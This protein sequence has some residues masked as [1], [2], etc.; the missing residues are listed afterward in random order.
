[1]RT[2]TSAELEQIGEMMS[3]YDLKAASEESTV[4]RR[5]LEGHLELLRQKLVSALRNYE[6]EEEV[7]RIRTEM[8]QIRRNL[9]Q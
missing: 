5:D 9:G 8:D 4:P 2:G 6:S 7:E 3:L 1:M